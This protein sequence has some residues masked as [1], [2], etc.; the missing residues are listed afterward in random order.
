MALRMARLKEVLA[1]PAIQGAVA[2]AI[3]VTAYIYSQVTLHAKLNSLNAVMKAS[4]ETLKAEM[5]ERKAEMNERKAEM[6]AS[7]ETPKAEMNEH[8]AEMKALEETRKAEMNE[9]KA[10]M[11]AS[12]TNMDRIFSTTMS[13]LTAFKDGID[14][15]LDRKIA[16]HELRENK[17]LMHVRAAANAKSSP[18]DLAL[19]GGYLATGAAAGALALVVY[20]RTQ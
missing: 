20:S 15:R 13:V 12:E 2:V 17:D 5:N 19:I 10:E 1:E 14:D 11:K 18:L 3:P 6:K 9:L 4:V 16:Q 7:E 8:K